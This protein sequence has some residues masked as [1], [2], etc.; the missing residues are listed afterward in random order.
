MG[1]GVAEAVAEALA[2]VVAEVCVDCRWAVAS[3]DAWTQ[4]V[5]ALADEEGGRDGWVNEP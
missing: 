2:G 5:V 3:P 4:A 1:K